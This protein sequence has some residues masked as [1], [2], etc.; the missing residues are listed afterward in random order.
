MTFLEGLQPAL[1]DRV[2]LSLWSLKVVGRTELLLLW[3]PPVCV[4]S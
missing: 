3:W 1:E 4:I 2:R